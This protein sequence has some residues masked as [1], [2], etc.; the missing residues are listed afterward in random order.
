MI[1]LRT[2]RFSGEEEGKKSSLGKKLGTAAAVIGGTALAV[3]AAKSGMLGGKAQM[4]VNKAWAQAGNALS[5]SSNQTIA[6]IGNS[7]KA[8]G[9][10]GYGAGAK[11]AAISNFASKNGLNNARDIVAA[12]G[13]KLGNR[14]RNIATSTLTSSLN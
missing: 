9:I 3:G 11:S 13:N 1:V 4:G 2:K 6:N 10:A 7:A 12:G 14:A 8:S 5:K